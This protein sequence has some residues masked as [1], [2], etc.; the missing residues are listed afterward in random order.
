MQ[1]FSSFFGYFKNQTWTHQ[2]GCMQ[3]QCFKISAAHFVTKYGWSCR[4]SK[5]QLHFLK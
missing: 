5:V 2:L 1:A 4:D 3:Q